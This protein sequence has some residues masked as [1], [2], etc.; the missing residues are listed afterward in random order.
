MSVWQKQQ[1][2]RP[3]AAAPRAVGAPTGRRLGLVLGGGGGKGGAHLGVLAVLEEHGVAPDMIVGTSIGGAIGVLYAAGHSIPAIAEIFRGS[4]L[5]RIASPDPSRMGLFSNRRRQ[6]ML[7]R[8][9][10]DRTFEQLPLPCAVVAADLLSGE[11][12]V[13]SSGPIV[14][15]LLASTAIPS[16]FTP[17]PLGERLLADGGILNNVPTNV[18]RALGA[19]RMIAVELTGVEPT[20]AVPT[21]APANPISRLTLAPRQFAIAARAIALLMAQ[22]TAA[23]LAQC[24]PDLLLQPDVGPLPTLDMNNPEAGYALGA[25]AARAAYGKLLELRAWREGHEGRATS[26]A[27]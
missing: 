3:H 23:R 22:A 8:I 19:E 27:D 1:D 2:W 6:T 4:A 24:P 7:E 26:S 15:A 18:A 10:G 17:V 20:F 11:E 21:V 12:V 13:I 16:I 9:F 25:A 5:R 14:P